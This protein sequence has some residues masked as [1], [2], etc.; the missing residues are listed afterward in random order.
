M[1]KDQFY[2]SGLPNSFDGNCSNCPFRR[3]S[4]DE[5]VCCETDNDVSIYVVHGTINKNCPFITK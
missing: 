4:F 3:D 2:H 1:A 5:M